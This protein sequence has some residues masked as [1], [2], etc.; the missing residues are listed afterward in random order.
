MIPRKL[1]EWVTMLDL[2][3]LIAGTAD[4]MMAEWARHRVFWEH[5]QMVELRG[6][7]N[8]VWWIKSHA[9]RRF[10]FV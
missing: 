10:C 3:C 5:S 2:F 4:L 8:H 1:G 9:S 6:S 7:A